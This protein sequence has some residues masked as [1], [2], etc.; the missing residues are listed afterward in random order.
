MRACKGWLR[1]VAVALI[2]VPYVALSQ[3]TQDLSTLG[4][5]TGGIVTS[6]TFVV[7]RGSG[8]GAVGFDG[9]MTQLMTYIASQIGGNCTATVT[10]ST[11]TMSCSGG[12]GGG[13]STFDQL[14]SGTNTTANM[15]CSTGC[16][17]GPSAGGTVNASWLDG[18]AP[19]VNCGIATTNGSGQIICVNG[20]TYAPLTYSAI[21]AIGCSS[22]NKGA[23]YYITDATVSTY[24]ANVT[25]GSGANAVLAICNGTNWQAH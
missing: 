16:F 5:V 14:G 22:A 6:D 15:F 9:T 13:A 3:S 18:A 8:A 17:F 10:G 12:G 1:W 25:A 19:A 7:I 23:A 4:P 24:L 20:N 2:A 11:I 21:N